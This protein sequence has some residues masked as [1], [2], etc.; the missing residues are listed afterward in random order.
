MIEPIPVY[1][2]GIHVMNLNGQISL[3]IIF[4]YIDKEKYYA[5][6]ARKGG[7]ELI[8]ELRRVM[9]NM[10]K[11]LDEEII[12]INDNLVKAKVHDV[13]LGFRGTTDRPYLE[14][15]ITLTGSSLRKGLNRYDNWYEEEIAEY[16][17]EIL[18]IFPENFK[19]TNYDLGGESVVMG[20]ENILRTIVKKGTKVG[21]HEWIEWIIL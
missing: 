11:F 7:S 10:Q 19:I 2:E 8:N 3:V 18:W 20:S 9:E 4:E 5:R 6:L 15:Y 14:F 1:A 12:K 16:D 17:Y 21:G 13:S